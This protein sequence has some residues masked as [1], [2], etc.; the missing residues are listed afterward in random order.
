MSEERN[1]AMKLD[2]EMLAAYIDKRLTPEQRAAV[3]AQ[4]A[5]DPDSYA[6]LVESMKALDAL[7]GEQ[8]T[9]P[10]VAK[11]KRSLPRWVTAAGVLAAAAAILIAIQTPDLLQRFRGER[12]DAKMASVLS[13]TGQERYIEPRLAAAFPYARAP[14]VSRGG[15]NSSRENLALVAVAGELQQEVKRDPAANVLHAFGVSQLLLGQWAE[16]I[17]TLEAALEADPRNQQLQLDLAA[18]YLARG[19]SSDGDAAKA[20]ALLERC[21]AARPDYLPA[22]FNKALALERLSLREQA[23]SAWQEYLSRDSSSG[24]ADEAAAHLAQLSAGVVEQ[25]WLERVRQFEAGRVRAADL[26]AADATL[27]R[28]YWERELL[29][30]W[31]RASQSQSDQAAAALTRLNDVAGALAAIGADRLAADTC[32]FVGSQPPSRELLA[33]VIDLERA[34]EL[35][36]Q[37]QFDAASAAFGAAEEGFRRL[38][39]PLA[40][41][42]RMHRGVTESIRRQIAAS[43]EILEP[44]ESTAA[45][46]GYYAIAG[47]AA[48]NLGIIAIGRGDVQV[49]LDH[50]ARAAESFRRGHEPA[51]TSFISNLTAEAYH[52]NG[53][54]S[55]SWPMVGDA[56]TSLPR[57]RDVRR[58]L[59]ILF[60]AGAVAEKNGL[61]ET[62]LHFDSAFVD[63]ARESGVF[64]SQVEGLLA[65]ARIHSTLARSAEATAD[66]TEAQQLIDD[67]KDR[68]RQQFLTGEKLTLAAELPVAATDDAQIIA[69]ADAAL[70]HMRSSN[71]LERLPRLHFAKGAALERMGNALAAETEYAAALDAFEHIQHPE[72]PAVLRA[73]RFDLVWDAVLRRAQLRLAAGDTEGALQIIE[74]AQHSSSGRQDDRAARVADLAGVLSSDVAIV[75]VVPFPSEVVAWVIHAG[76]IQY[77]V[78]PGTPQQF[79]ADINRLRQSIAF[80]S[81]TFRDRATDLYNR[82]FA[83][84]A[85]DLNVRVLIICPNGIFGRLPWH[86]LRNPQ[87]G[88]FLAEDYLISVNARI[89]IAPPDEAVGRPSFLGVGVGT[90]MSWRDQLLPALRNAPKEVAL[91]A[92][93]YEASKTLVD[94]A[95]TKKAFLANAAAA[96]VIH[97]AA[98]A[99]VDEN[100]P[101]S[102][103]LIL[104]PEGSDDGLL[105]VDGLPAK[106]L[107]RTQLVVLAA[108]GTAEGKPFRGNG[109]VTLSRA[110][111]DAGAQS[112]IGTLWEVGDDDALAVSESLHT[113]LARERDPFAVFAQVQRDLIARLPVRAWA[114]YQISGVSRDWFNGNRQPGGE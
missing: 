102:S 27:A 28:E 79:E 105:R 72:D 39:S 52:L 45:A 42:A 20:L 54:A 29:P 51:L 78:L 12:V 96:A 73:T 65:R 85:D 98:H 17:G 101:F 67:H 70:D 46:S 43:Q 25:E 6:V 60:V 104:A 16:A 53:Y 107:R 110:F 7:D 106:L 74:D 1:P 94:T 88:R 82:T 77:K 64:A 24:W 87:S 26:V 10:F 111:L 59:S 11:K 9:V 5:S 86:V 55:A 56:L 91:A 15:N 50:Y 95:A 48:W 93:H 41:A 62:A 112:V 33:G 108:C 71:R 44:I 103:S 84:L 68:T 83:P 47:R 3:E 66:L 32:A 14:Q 99:V 4:L 76:V 58:R 63:L 40:L 97:I 92:T 80:E 23:R 2:P 89:G 8:R 75:D 18:A 36:D 21:L 31:A 90:P 57:S 100:N 22:L 114:A 13:A 69:A 37:Y 61:P 30:A 35:Y 113:S 109:M 38:G 19:S 49:G 81:G 34:R